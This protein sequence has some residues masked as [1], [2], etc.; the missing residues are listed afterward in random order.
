MRSDTV[1]YRLR[2]ARDAGDTALTA[3]LEKSLEKAQARECARAAELG[4]LTYAAEAFERR[5]GR[6][7]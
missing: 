6:R 5:F 7:A 1:L 4:R 3:R 2:A